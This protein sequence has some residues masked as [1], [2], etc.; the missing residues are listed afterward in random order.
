MKFNT[1]TVS[2]RD[3]EFEIR[4]LSIGELLPLIKTLEEDSIAG[5]RLLMGKSI[6]IDGE[7]LGEKYD[8][9]PASIMMK[10]MPVVMEVNSLGEVEGND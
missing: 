6:Y 9:M 5:Q 7:Q 4:E 2:I 10:L 3:T 1:E 8:D